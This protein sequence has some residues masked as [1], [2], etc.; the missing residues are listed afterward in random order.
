[1]L[2]GVVGAEEAAVLRFDNRVDTIGISSGNG[3]ADP[4]ENSVR[5]TIP[6]Q[7]FPCPSARGPAARLSAQPRHRV[8]DCSSARKARLQSPPD[9]AR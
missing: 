3:D 8:A 9:T 2:A 6:F 1:M 4:A 7:A 5:K